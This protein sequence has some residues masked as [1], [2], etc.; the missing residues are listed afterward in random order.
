MFYLKPFGPETNMET[1][2][3]HAALDLARR[4]GFVF[5]ST[6]Q[7][8]GFPDTRVMFNLLKLR[9]GILTGGP[10]ALDSPF[11]SWLGTNTSSQKVQQ[12][13]KDPRVCLYY[14]DTDAF[15][16][17]TLQGTVEEIQDRGIKQAIWMD[18]WEMY[19][20]GGLDGGDFTVLRFKP[21]RG[22]YYHGLKVMEFNASAAGLQA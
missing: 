14:A 15:E 19:Y 6:L 10:A 18:G 7:N 4:S 1:P 12:I 3:V 20:P 8:D 2:L 13:R 9:A 22:R 21:E 16:G 17:L 11:E 5:V